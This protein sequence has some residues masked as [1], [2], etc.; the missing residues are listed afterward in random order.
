MKKITK[1][2]SVV[3]ALL[4]LGTVAGCSNSKTISLGTSM[5]NAWAY[6]YQDIEVPIGLYLNYMSIA[7]QDASSKYEGEGMTGDSKIK[8]N[9][10]KEVTVSEYVKS[11]A[12]RYCM[13]YIAYQ[14]DAKNVV[15]GTDY[16]YTAE[17]VD[18]YVDDYFSQMESMYAMYGYTGYSRDSMYSSVEGMGVSKQ[19]YDASIAYE[20]YKDAIFKG[21]YATGGKQEVSNDELEKYFTES[22]THYRYVFASYKTT[23]TVEGADTDTTT[24]VDITDELKKEYK[25]VFEGIANSTE[26][27][28]SFG[29]GVLDYMKKYEITSDPTVARTEKLDN[30]SA[31]EDVLAAVKELGDNK[32]K[33]VEAE[34]GIYVVF[35]G[36]IKEYVDFLTIEMPTIETETTDDTADET[37]D[38]T[39]DADTADTE[40][41]SAETEPEYKLNEVTS[42]MNRDTL[43]YEYKDEDFKTYT[44]DIVAKIAGDVTS[45]DKEI[46]K[47]D[48]SMFAAE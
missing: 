25:E 39:E 30:S 22:Y 46:S 47:Y 10:D 23:E 4:M 34:D 11:E 6:R 31:N 1:I 5:E 15:E 17:D 36:D 26:S 29:N 35:K 42:G 20:Y 44:A 32:A 33:V 41:D 3:L 48:V 2:V 43:L 38:A 21:L 24:E 12:K 9:D 18:K 19:S 8:D 37:A 16:A 27:A 45:N 13:E 40:A 7:Y 28:E 14:M